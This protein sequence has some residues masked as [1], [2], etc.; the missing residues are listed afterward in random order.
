VAHIRW[1]PEGEAILVL[2]DGDRVE[3][4]S[5]RSFPPG[6]RPRGAV[7]AEGAAGAEPAPSREPAP[8]WIKVHGSHRQP[9]GRFRV[10]GR[11][12]D[13]TRA[14]RERLARIVVAS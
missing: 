5:S 1:E 2:L 11:L 8:F 7:V 6:A 14:L 13:A 9:D 12:L 10:E 3:L 4:L